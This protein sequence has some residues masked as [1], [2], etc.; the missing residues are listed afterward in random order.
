VKV[1]TFL[2]KEKE[3]FWGERGKIIFGKKWV[4]IM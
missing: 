1:S 4:V 2:I 3:F